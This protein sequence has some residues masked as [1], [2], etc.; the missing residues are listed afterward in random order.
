MIAA[1]QALIA[2]LT[3]RCPLHCVY[4]SNP[5]EMQS[6]DRELSTEAWTGIIEAEDRAETFAPLITFCKCPVVWATSIYG[7]RSC[8]QT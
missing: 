5:I 3:H 7:R 1:P 2:E 8:Q 4:C 6:R